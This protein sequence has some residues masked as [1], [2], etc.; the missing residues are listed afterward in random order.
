MLG[1]PT[2]T[3]IRKIITKKKVYEQF[4][5]EMSA[6]RRK[7]FD[8]DIARMVLTNEVS[9]A[10]VNL[11]AGESVQS[12]FVLQVAL[13]TKNFDSQNIACLAKLFGQRL[14]LVLEAEACQRL[15]VWQ[16]RL[17]MTEWA[18]ANVETLPLQGLDLDKV[19]SNIVAQIAGIEVQQDAALDEQ[20]ARAA[21]QERLQKEIARLEK[22]ARA[23][24]QPR[25]KFELAQQIKEKRQL[26]E[27]V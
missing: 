9:P 19:W 14:V 2:S 3:E 8:A 22:K 11:P 15:A 7:K 16:T 4:S 12:F 18:E 13:K 27:K 10:S 17:L 26:L 25:K 20:L 24:Q 6:E 23:E 5:A 1:L 21:Q